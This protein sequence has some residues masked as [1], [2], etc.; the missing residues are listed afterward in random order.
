VWFIE[1][2][3]VNGQAGWVEGAIQENVVLGEPNIS[4]ILIA[5]DVI[6]AGNFAN[7]ATDTPQFTMA[8]NGTTEP[9]AVTFIDNGDI[10]STPSTPSVP[11]TGTTLPLLSLAMAAL[12][13][14]KS[15][16]F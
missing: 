7:D 16:L 5:S 3:G 6:G 9:L 2:A 4:K 8:I 11:D 1:L 13:L 15:R 12:G 10:P 14:A